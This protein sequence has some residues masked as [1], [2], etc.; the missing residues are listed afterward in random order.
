VRK[1]WNHCSK[2]LFLSSIFTQN[3][4]SFFLEVEVDKKEM[5]SLFVQSRSK[6]GKIFFE[7]VFWNQLQI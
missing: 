5:E 7:T 1:V 2:P 3:R 4:F 6:K